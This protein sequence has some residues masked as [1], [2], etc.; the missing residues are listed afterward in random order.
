MGI[1]M[2]VGK[3]CW[4]WLPHNSPSYFSN[5]FLE[6]SA[7]FSLHCDLCVL[8]VSTFIHAAISTQWLY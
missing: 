5:T 3:L 4:V 2:P 8:S 6:A 7:R 1:D